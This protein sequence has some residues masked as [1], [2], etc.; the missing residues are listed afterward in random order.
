MLIRIIRLDLFRPP[1]AFALALA[2][3]LAPAPGQAQGEVV[4]VRL[5][6]V[7]AEIAKE[8]N[9]EPGKLPAT[10]AIPLAAAA[11]VCGVD[12]NALAA[13]GTGVRPSCSATNAALALPYVQNLVR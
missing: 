13:P 6:Q 8:L 10:A 5:D 11:K 2:V 4:D 1:V 12:L 7:R 3:A 9:L